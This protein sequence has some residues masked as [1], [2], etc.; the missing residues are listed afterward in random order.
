MTWQVP[1]SNI[2]DPETA[3][4]WWLQ[5]HFHQAHT[6]DEGT[7]AIDMYASYL[8]AAVDTKKLPLFSG[9]LFG[10]IVGTLVPRTMFRSVMT[11]GVRRGGH[12]YL[13]QPLD[14]VDVFLNGKSKS[15]PGAM[16]ALYA[17]ACKTMGSRQIWDWQEFEAVQARDKKV[18]EQWCTEHGYRPVL[19]PMQGVETKTKALYELFVKSNAWTYQRFNKALATIGLVKRG[20]NGSHKVVLLQKLVQA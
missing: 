12:T 18:L 9:V 13:V 6:P 2:A 5:K 10:R 4:R 11:D 17:N 16:K 1:D 3:V 19:P 15:G 8:D 20:N 14:G 7:W